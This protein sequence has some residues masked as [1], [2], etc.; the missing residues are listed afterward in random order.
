MPLEL[1]RI[2]EATTSVIELSGVSALVLGFLINVGSYLRHYRHMAKPDLAKKFKRGLG[3]TVIIGLEILVAATI[4]K[5]VTN[6][7]TL[8]SI[9]LLAGMIAVRTIISWTMVLEMNGRWPWQS[10]HRPGVEAVKVSST[11]DKI[12]PENG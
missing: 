7:E 1:V 6:E 3:R 11:T 2:L 5:T 8:R 12:E 4:V 9:G 10:A